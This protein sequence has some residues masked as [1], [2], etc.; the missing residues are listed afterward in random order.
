[1]LYGTPV[2]LMH[3]DTLCTRDIIYLKARKKGRNRFYQWLFLC[4]PLKTRKAIANK[5]RAKSTRHTQSTAIEI[6]DVT[7][8]DV[9]YVMQ[10][11]NVRYLIH[12]HTHRPNIHEFSVNNT[13]A[14]RIVLGAWHDGGSMLVWDESSS[15]SLRPCQRIT[16]TFNA[17]MARRFERT[18]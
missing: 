6:M 16:S 2:L 5:M 12:G 17:H 3:G 7:Q 8:E 15:I 10:K 4:L 9:E 13:K 11:H 18:E 14:A 1:M